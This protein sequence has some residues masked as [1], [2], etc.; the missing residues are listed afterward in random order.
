MSE[1][2]PNEQLLVAIARLRVSMASLSRRIRSNCSFHR[3]KQRLRV[4]ADT[5]RGRFPHSP[6]LPLLPPTP[7]T[8]CMP[9]FWAGRDHQ[10]RRYTCVSPHRVPFR[11]RFGRS[12]TA[13]RTAIKKPVHMYPSLSPPPSLSPLIPSTGLLGNG[14]RLVQ[15]SSTAT[16]TPARTLQNPASPPRASR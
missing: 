2:E 15:M 14:F 7:T 3:K 4:D 9:G 5:L 1:R 12:E 13:M 6:R 11:V 8:K 16:P 10:Q